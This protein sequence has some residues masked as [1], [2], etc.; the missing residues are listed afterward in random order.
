MPDRPCVTITLP[1]EQQPGTRKGDDKTYRKTL[2][3][4]SRYVLLPHSYLRAAVLADTV[5]A[6][7]EKRP[8]ST[9]NGVFVRYEEV[10]RATVAWSA[11]PLVNDD[12]CA[13]T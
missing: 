5:F 1:R 10:P 7:V 6:G 8:F 2:Q 3:G 12:M 4:L 9:E 13:R 11:R